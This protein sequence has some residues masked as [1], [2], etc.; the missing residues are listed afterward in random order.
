MKTAALEVLPCKL[1][2][3]LA[4]EVSTFYYGFFLWKK[5]NLMPNE[6][7]THKESGV[8]AILAIVIVMIMIVIVVSDDKCDDYDGAYARAYDHAYDY[9]M[10][11][12]M[13]T[14]MNTWV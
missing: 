12:F 8:V 13:L 11:M 1:A 2:S 7:S 14:N 6:Y 4:I 10:L 3:F 5:K 9:A